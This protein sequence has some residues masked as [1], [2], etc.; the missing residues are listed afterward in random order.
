MALNITHLDIFQACIRSRSCH[1][2]NDYFKQKYEALS[3]SLSILNK[4]H[5]YCVFVAKIQYESA[6]SF[7]DLESVVGRGC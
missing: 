1:L 5:Y 7:I 3:L 6:L 4:N 2:S